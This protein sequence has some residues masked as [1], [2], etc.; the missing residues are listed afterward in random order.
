MNDDEAD[1]M[2]RDLAHSTGR[3]EMAIGLFLLVLGIAI[4]AVGLSGGG[5][6]LVPLGIIGAGIAQLVRGGGRLAS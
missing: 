4:L 5:I 6:V 1:Q 3:R 2:I